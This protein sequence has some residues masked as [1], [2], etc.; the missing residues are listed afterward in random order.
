MLSHPH[1]DPST[2]ITLH[3]LQGGCLSFKELSHGWCSE[4]CRIIK[5]HT[6]LKRRNPSLR[7]RIFLVI[8]PKSI[9]IAVSASLVSMSHDEDHS[10]AWH[11]IASIHPSK[12]IQYTHSSPPCV[13][14][15][16]DI[17]FPFLPCEKK[18]GKAQTQFLRSKNVIEIPYLFDRPS[19][20]SIFAFEK[21]GPKSMVRGGMLFL[22]VPHNSTR[23][24]TS[25]THQVD[26]QS[27]KN[28]WRCTET[29]RSH[30]IPVQKVQPPGLLDR[31]PG[32]EYPLSTNS[33]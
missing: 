32:D 30:R 1:P 16:P 27:A 29:A 18:M 33:Q 13:Y 19:E 14:L 9:V 7:F 11:L 25:T 31:A 28:M 20:T 8:W 15:S 21:K 3:S 24:E 5:I 26:D 6:T 2:C 22:I 23:E 10:G 12:G 17:M 4:A